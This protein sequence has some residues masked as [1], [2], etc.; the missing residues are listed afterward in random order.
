MAGSLRCP[1]RTAI[2]TGEYPHDDGVFTNSGS[3]GG[4]GAYMSH[5]DEQRSFA[6]ALQKA[7]TACW[8][9]AHLSNP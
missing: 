7:G 3:D 1:S 8:A 9:A 2:F 6:L 4:Y 5:D